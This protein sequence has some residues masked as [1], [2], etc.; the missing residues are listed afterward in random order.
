MCEILTHGSPT[1]KYEIQSPPSIKAG[2]HELMVL[3]DQN[4][5]TVFTILMPMMI[6]MGH[7]IGLLSCGSSIKWQIILYI[8]VKLQSMVAGQ[9]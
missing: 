4:F 2:P 1:Y 5:C 3:P 6:Q 9:R 8:M 7:Q